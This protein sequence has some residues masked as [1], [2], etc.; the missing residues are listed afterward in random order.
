MD[1]TLNIGKSLRKSEVETG[2]WFGLVPFS[3]IVGTVQ[4]LRSNI[5]IHPFSAEL[6]WPLHRFYINRFYMPR[7]ENLDTTSTVD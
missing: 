2:E 5:A 6:Q 3:S 4:F 7:N 1:R